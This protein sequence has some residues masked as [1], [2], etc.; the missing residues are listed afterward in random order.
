MNY[1]TAEYICIEFDLSHNLANEKQTLGALVL[2][3]HNGNINDGIN[4]AGC[5]RP[6][7][8]F[9]FI[10]ISF[11][12]NMYDLYDLIHIWQAMQ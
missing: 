3:I 9:L 12:R 6:F 5:K 8:E 1:F 4:S 7:P 10:D 2:C 11:L